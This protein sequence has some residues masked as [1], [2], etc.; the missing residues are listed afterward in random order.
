V[1]SSIEKVLEEKGIKV[2]EGELELLEQQWKAIQ[3]LKNGIET[4]KLNDADIGITHHPGGVS[5]KNGSM[6]KRFPNLRRL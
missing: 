2:S 1:R 6:R 4:S 5:W 3:Q